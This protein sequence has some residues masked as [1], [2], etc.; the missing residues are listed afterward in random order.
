MD[1]MKLSKYYD[2]VKIFLGMPKDIGFEYMEVIL[3]EM[4]E[5]GMSW[6]EAYELFGAMVDYVVVCEA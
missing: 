2:S 4:A 5:D 6:S 3:D 1:E